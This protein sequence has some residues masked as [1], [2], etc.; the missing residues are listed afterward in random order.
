MSV[1]APGRA[2]VGP[3]WARVAVIFAGGFL[4]TA[5]RVALLGLVGHEHVALG[6]VNVL[7]CLAIGLISGCFG[8]RVTLWRLFLA[9]GGV[10]AFTS[11]SSLALQG[12]E[13][14]GAV[15]IVVAETI[16]GVVAAGLGHLL[17]WRYLRR[18]GDG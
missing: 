7:G 2:V 16:V 15:I 3:L 8:P 9:V 4:G 1:E 13:S 14:F 5:A 18:D 11:W 10:A 17:G 6:V 12:M